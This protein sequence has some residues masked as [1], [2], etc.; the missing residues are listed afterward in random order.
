MNLTISELS[1]VAFELLHFIASKR[2]GVG[3]PIQMGV[4]ES[5]A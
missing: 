2:L 3:S 5:S 1:F 4:N